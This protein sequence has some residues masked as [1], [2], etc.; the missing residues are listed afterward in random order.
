[1]NIR[2]RG[3]GAVTGT[4]DMVFTAPAGRHDRDSVPVQP[5]RGAHI[6]IARDP[7]RGRS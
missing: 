1:M 2:D 6:G 5:D 4:G 7:R 3:N